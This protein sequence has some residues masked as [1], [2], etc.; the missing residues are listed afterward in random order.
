MGVKFGKSS[1]KRPTIV[2]GHLDFNFNKRT[3]L[4]ESS[5][6]FFFFIKNDT[7]I[8]ELDKEQY[9]ETQQKAKVQKPYTSGQK[10]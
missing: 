2:L 5:I 1:Y 4:R 7:S 9:K 6:F 8:E 10:N 3:Q